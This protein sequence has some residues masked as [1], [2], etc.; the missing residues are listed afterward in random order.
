MYFYYN[1]Q[2]LVKMRSDSALEEYGTLSR[3]AITP[4]PEDQEK[5][6][7][8]YI[9]KI[10]DDK[11]DFEKHP[12]LK[13]REMEEEKILLRDKAKNGKLTISDVSEFIT[14]FL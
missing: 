9:I 3:V 6:D 7:Q 10:K 1:N 4:M 2:G 5:I 14:K 13:N 12:Q 8:N 11:L